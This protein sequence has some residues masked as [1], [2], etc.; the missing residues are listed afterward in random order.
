MSENE[1]R[2]QVEHIEGH[3]ESTAIVPHQGTADIVEIQSDK[4]PDIAG[5][6][7]Q[8]QKA[9]SEM[10]PHDLCVEFN[11]EQSGGRSSTHFRLRAYRY[12]NGK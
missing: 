9:I 10:A 8:L 2:K 1:A 12:K 7:S 4:V 11:S 3:R 6:V 5:A